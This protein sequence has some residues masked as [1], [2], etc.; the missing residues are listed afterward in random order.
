MYVVFPWSTWPLAVMFRVNG[1]LRLMDI[2]YM[3]AKRRR[4][5]LPAHLRPHPL[6]HVFPQV[7]LAPLSAFRMAN[8]AYQTDIMCPW[9]LLHVSREPFNLA[10]FRCHAYTVASYGPSL[11]SDVSALQSNQIQIHV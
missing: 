11:R 2:W 8:T 7:R 1:A 6:R 5:P 4:Q 9:S 3:V 10:R